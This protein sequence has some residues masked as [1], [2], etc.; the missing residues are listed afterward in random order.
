VS[1]LYGQT[2]GGI[3]ER[4]NTYLVATYF[5]NAAFVGAKTVSGLVGV[6]CLIALSNPLPCSACSNI[7]SSNRSTITCATVRP[8]G[9][10]C[11]AGGRSTQSMT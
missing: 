11:G 10:G 6:A 4:P 1:V 7:D 8:V 2:V 5:R 3:W 9:N